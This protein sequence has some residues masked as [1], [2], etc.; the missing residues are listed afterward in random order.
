MTVN[1]ERHNAKP[2]A[3]IARPS[4][5]LA[6][7]VQPRGEQQAEAV[8]QVRAEETKEGEGMIL[9]MKRDG[10]E[11]TIAGVGAMMNGE[12]MRRREWIE[13]WFGPRC[14]DYDSSCIICKMWRNQ[15][16]FDNLVDL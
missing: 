13:Q 5:L 2:M 10:V 7:R 8:R 16:Q 4:K 14:P 1:A 11:F 6:V 9:K 15:D 12:S 3:K